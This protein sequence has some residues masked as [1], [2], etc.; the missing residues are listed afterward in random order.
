MRFLSE[1]LG[2]SFFICLCFINCISHVLFTFGG[3]VCLVLSASA[4]WTQ[5]QTRQDIFVLSRPSFDEFCLASTHFPISK[6]SVILNIFETEQLQIGN[7][8][9]TRQNS[10]VLFVSAVWTSYD[11]PILMSS[12]Y[13]NII[14]FDLTS[15]TM[16]LQE[17]ALF[18]GAYDIVNPFDGNT[19]LLHTCTRSLLTI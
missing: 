15:R 8:V 17:P 10:F 12:V 14:K 7:W 11:L 5:V 4:V 6:F 3:F 18:I 19:L 13:R 2:F 16:S 9:E 1:M